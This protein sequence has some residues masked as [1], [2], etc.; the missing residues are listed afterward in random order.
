MRG[1]GVFHANRAIV[2]C[3]A[4][5]RE[6]R[7]IAAFRVLRPDHSRGMVHAPAKRADGDRP[8]SDI[9]C[10]SWREAEFAGDKPRRA[11]QHV[12][13]LGILHQSIDRAIPIGSNRMR[14]AA[15]PGQAIATLHGPVSCA[16]ALAGSSAPSER[17]SR[18]R[19]QR[20]INR[21]VALS[22]GKSRGVKPYAL[23]EKDHAG[24]RHAS[25]AERRLAA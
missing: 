23:Q 20:S 9:D 24:P 11:W 6:V 17:P 15:Q 1:T 16:K 14:P 2:G 4:H 8:C 3:R 10:H 21:C 13:C 18:R 7:A 19:R 12:Q 5:V 25:N 22:R